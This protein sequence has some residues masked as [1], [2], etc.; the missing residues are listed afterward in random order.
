VN[1]NLGTALAATGS[2]EEAIGYLRRAVQLAPDNQYARKE[3]EL[4]LR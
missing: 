2:R 4:L 3:L 1:R